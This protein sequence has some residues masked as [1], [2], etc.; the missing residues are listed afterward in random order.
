MKKSLLSAVLAATISLHGCSSLLNKADSDM[1]VE[2]FYSEA[3]EAFSEENWDTAIENYEKLKAY[4]PY[5]KFA[6]QSYLE[7]AYAYYRYDEPESAIRETEE[8]IKLYPKHPSSAYAYYLRAVAADSVTKSWLD[9]WIT[10]PAQ[11][12]MVSSERAFG[13]YEALLQRFPETD[14]ATAARERLVIIRNRMARHELQVAKFYFDRQAY[15][16]AANRCRQLIEDYPRA[17]INLEA[18]QLM[19]DSYAALGMQQNYLDTLKVLELNSQI[20]AEDRAARAEE[21]AK[22]EAPAKQEEKSWW[23]SLTSLFD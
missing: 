13:F 17:V 8:F 12:D 15:L 19:K 18:L 7:L 1:T 10:D 3:T 21:L 22:I 16:A 9:K 5:G 4:F 14:Y 2:E 20:Q 6:E 23:Q 11:R